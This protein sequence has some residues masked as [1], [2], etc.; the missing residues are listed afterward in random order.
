MCSTLFKK[1]K[2]KQKL[3]ETRLLKGTTRKTTGCDAANDSLFWMQGE[4]TLPTPFASYSIARTQTLT[5]PSSFPPPSLPPPPLFSLGLTFFLFLVLCCCCCDCL[6]SLSLSG[7]F[8]HVF[9]FSLSYC[10]WTTHC[11]HKHCTIG[12]KNKHKTNQKT[13]QELVKQHPS[14]P[15]HENCW[16]NITK[17]L[18]WN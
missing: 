8:V 6:F 12:R 18:Y 7:L 17:M 1:R 2:M 4:G 15:W 13:K 16:G 14:M 10:F 3:K 9:S 5:T 11:T